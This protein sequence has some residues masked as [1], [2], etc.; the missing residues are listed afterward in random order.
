MD[1]TRRDALAVGALYL[2]THVTSVTALVLYGPVVNHIDHLDEA[3]S[4]S[5]FAGGL[6]EVIL[7]LAVV[8]TAVALYP[9]VRR[10]S[11]AGAVGY[12]AL[13]T[14]E[15]STIL[16]GVVTLLAAVTV[17]QQHSGTSDSAS[18]VV[19]GQALVAVHNW[20]FL[21]GVGLVVGVH[22]VVLA[23]ALYR[24][25]LVARFIPVLGLVGGPLV[26]AS[27]IGVMFGAY[28]QASTIT[29]VGAVPVFAWEISLAGYLI[30]KGFR[31]NPD[32]AAEP[33]REAMS[34]Q[35]VSSHK[36]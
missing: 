26:F 13:R 29:A 2:I 14:L 8:G 20:I 19:A 34:R 10:H 28:P 3:D 15:A 16:V 23:Y 25:R 17:R 9:T 21:I 32:H 35:L 6:L 5:V 11:P 1:R 36:S 31:T 30:V 12:V 4:V 24:S 22:T 27:N 18:S 7:A 33:M